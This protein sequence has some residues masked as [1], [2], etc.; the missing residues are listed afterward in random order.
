[1]T[2]ASATIELQVATAEDDQ[3]AIKRALESA[4]VTLDE[5]RDQARLGRYRNEACRW[6]WISNS[7]LVG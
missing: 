4:G 7:A 6:A 1:M 3:V 2:P 5:L